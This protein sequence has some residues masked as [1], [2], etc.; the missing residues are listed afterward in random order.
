[1]SI[2]MDTA[3]MVTGVVEASQRGRVGKGLGWDSRD[4]RNADDN[5]GGTQDDGSRRHY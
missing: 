3:M 1:L 2:M 5:W 4:A